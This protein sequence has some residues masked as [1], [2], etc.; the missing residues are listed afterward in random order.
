[1]TR[2]QIAQAL[3]RPE[4]WVR[5]TFARYDPQLGLDSL[6]DRS[7]RPHHSPSQTPG[8][9]EDAIC[10]LKQ[11]HPAWGRRQ[12][13]KQLRWQWRADPLRLRWVSESRVR[14]V[15]ARHP[16][17]APPV[18][19]RDCFPPRQIDY[20]ECNLLW[21]ADI[22]QTKLEDGS[23][24][25]TLHWLDLHSRYEL[26]QVTAPRLTEE[27]V[28]QSF[29]GV[30]KEHGLPRL[31]KTDGD[32]LFYDATSGLPSQFSRVLAALGIHHLVMPKKQ[33]W[34]NGVVERYIRTWRQEVHLPNHGNGQ[35]MNQASDSVR[36]FYNHE[37]C[38][39]RC[40]DQPPATLY[41]AS[42]RRLPADFDRNQVPI[43]L[44]PTVVTR[45]VQASGRISL[46]GQSYPFS[47]RYAGQ[48][49]TVTVE[50]WMATAQSP[51]GWHRTFDLHP[52]TEQLPPATLP[53]SSPKP[54][55]RKVNRR[56][57]ISLNRCL[58]YVGLA[59]MGQTL[60]LETTQG[61]SWLVTLPDGSTKTLP[62]KHLLPLPRPS[63]TPLRPETPPSPQAKPATLHSRRVTKTGQISFYHRLYYVGIARRGQNVYVAPTPDGLAVYD[64]DHAWITTCL[65]K[66]HLRPDKPL[67]PT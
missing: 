31:V 52:N 46:A 58:Y 65:W 62:K 64:T 42:S 39:S 49:V 63:A 10:A 30:A 23:V 59:W 50:G 41:Q 7:S 56:G 37:R 34:W 1:M 57:C 3:H 36:H 43:T 32:K 19:Q 38:H 2:G 67:C 16:E 29:L 53:P 6:R 28:V 51:D 54:L 14:R 25:E 33:P 45:R 13:A 40:R 35:Q 55:S 60:V 12:I 26:G 47:R 15:L 61:E 20:L 9:V 24:W 8:E 66:G 44:Q 4:R 27:V 21:A 5:R 11:T 48:S 22:H 17:L 18:P